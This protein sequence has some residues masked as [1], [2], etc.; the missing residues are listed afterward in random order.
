MARI[1]YEKEWQHI[2]THLERTEIRLLK[3]L[4][5][6]TADDERADA[7]GKLEQVRAQ[8]I[9]ARAQLTILNERRRVREG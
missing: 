5:M 9:Q 3:E 4:E 8:M 2:V 1:N 7:A 6:S